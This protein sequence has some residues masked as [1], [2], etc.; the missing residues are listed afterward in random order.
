MYYKVIGQHEPERFRRQFP[1][2]E[3]VNTRLGARG[4]VKDDCILGSR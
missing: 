1:P 3:H 2:I 4:A